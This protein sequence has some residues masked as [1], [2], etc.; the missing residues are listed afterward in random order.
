MKALAAHE[1]MNPDAE[2]LLA[3]ILHPAAAHAGNHAQ[4]IEP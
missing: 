2:D 4:V 3:Q 1:G